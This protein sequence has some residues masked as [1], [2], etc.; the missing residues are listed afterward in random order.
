MDLRRQL[1]LALRRCG[2]AP[3]QAASAYRRIGWGAWHDAYLAT[4][5]D[6]EQLVVRLRK[7]LIYGR[8]EQFDEQALREEY[9][10]VGAYYAHANKVWPGVCP[11]IYA[12][13]IQ[14]DL[15]DTIES[16]MG[17]AIDLAS[18]SA[19]AA[20]DYG[21]QLGALFRAI[22]A[23]PPPIDGFGEL[24]WREGR[25]IGCQPR[26]LAAIWHADIARTQSQLERLLA[27]GLSFDRSAVRSVV[28]AALAQR[29]FVAEP[30]ALV[31][32][33][34]TPE[35]MLLRLN[36][37][38]ALID[39]VPLLHNPTRYASLLCFCYTFLL[40]ALSTAPRYAR[41]QF[42]RHA[43]PMAAIAEGYVD[44]YTQDTTA[45]DR[46]SIASRHCGCWTR[47]MAIPRCY[48]E[49][50]ARNNGYEPAANLSSRPLCSLACGPWSANRRSS[51]SM[52]PIYG[53][54]CYRLWR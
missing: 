22:H 32:R 51:E 30:V 7:K 13:H 45:S 29:S 14:P 44:G 28:E 26:D 3:L 6:G 25:L 41:H 24:I 21:Q 40:P 53:S 35:N 34:V 12:Y 52:E 18:L 19:T 47:S 27:S 17:A 2:F 48:T 36:G 20:F 8:H 16:Y 4:L 5:R 42:Q 23:Q 1:D 15:S 10:S 43:P 39:P 46:R 54:T 9:A 37:A 31:N 38:A 49:R 50:S 11:A 33:D